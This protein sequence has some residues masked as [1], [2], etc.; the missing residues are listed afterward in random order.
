MANLYNI[1]LRTGCLC[2]PGACQRHL[3]L[4]PEDVKIHFKV[5]FIYLFIIIQKNNK[6]DNEF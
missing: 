2:N 1:H 4:S 6:N 5:F 3:Q